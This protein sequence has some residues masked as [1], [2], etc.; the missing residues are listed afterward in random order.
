LRITG[1]NYHRHLELPIEME[2]FFEI[3]RLLHAKATHT[4]QEVV[5]AFKA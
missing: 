1:H 3:A 4:R 2:Q 5:A